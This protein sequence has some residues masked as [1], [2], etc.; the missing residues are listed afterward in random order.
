MSCSSPGIFK[1]LLDVA[2]QLCR[3]TKVPDLIRI[4]ANSIL[5][6]NLLIQK[7]YR[8]AIINIHQLMLCKDNLL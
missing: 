1:I 4:H 6:L 8:V 2:T 5:G 3:R 7:T